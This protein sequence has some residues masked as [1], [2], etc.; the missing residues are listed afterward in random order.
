MDTDNV[1]IDICVHVLS[2]ARLLRRPINMV[3]LWQDECNAT[4][5]RVHVIK[6]ASSDLNCTSDTCR[7]TAS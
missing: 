4:S 5:R 3:Y 7:R 6:R 2:C 1:T